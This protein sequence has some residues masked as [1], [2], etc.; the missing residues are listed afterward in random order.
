MKKLSDEQE[1]EIIE[2]YTSG[3]SI[4]A[5][6]KKLELSYCVVREFLSNNGITRPNSEA[7]KNSKKHTFSDEDIANIVNLYTNE[8]IGIGKLSSQF[9]TTQHAIKK[10]L[11][12]NNVPLRDIHAINTCWRK[13]YSIPVETQT[14]I[15]ADYIKNEYSIEELVHKY[16][17]TNKVLISL[18][19]N[20][21]VV[22]RSKK[23]IYQIRDKKS[24]KHWQTMFG[25]NNPQ[26]IKEVKQKTVATCLLKY[27]VT[28]GGASAAA[29]EKINN[30][31]QKHYGQHYFATDT[32]KEIKEA[33]KQSKG[34]FPDQFGS[35]EHEQAMLNKYGRVRCCNTRY[36]YDNYYFDSFPELALYLYCQATGKSIIRE[37]SKLTFIYNNQKF[38]YVP[39]FLIEGQL[40]EIKG[41]QFLAEDG[42][43]YNPYKPELSALMEAKHQCAIANN[44]KILYAKD[45]QQYLDWFKES[46]YNKDDYL[47][48][49]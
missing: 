49:V 19:Q 39:D 12:E 42:S 13:C 48:K 1:K 36:F 27:G 29:R 41:E 9:H 30:T 18:L 32:F 6:S 15:I 34:Y 25:V 26:Q 3:E 38:N 22:L 16:K 45:Y 20:N 7:Q 24:I 21:N 28:N 8:H 44:V 37:P 4:M 31:M 23:E 2:I 5:T 46:G 10:L 17:F 33:I 14:Q 43:W 11:L 35:P 47:I 40:V